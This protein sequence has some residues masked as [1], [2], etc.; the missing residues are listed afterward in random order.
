MINKLY[1]LK[2]SQLNQQLILKRQLTNRIFEIDK[3]ILD[4][5]YKLSSAGVEKFGA[6]G[7]FKILAIHKNSM[8]YEKSILLQEKETLF[9]KI[10]QFDNI[11]IELQKEIEKYDY[12]LKQELKQK[13]KNERKQDEMI[14]SEYVLSKYARVS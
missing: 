10:E 2:Q 12:L 1:K 8:K 7:D 13:L 14:A 4:I 5:D 3:N 11:I 9:I 6:I